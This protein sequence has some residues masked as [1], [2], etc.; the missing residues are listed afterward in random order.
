MHKKK[1]STKITTTDNNSLFHIALV[2]ILIFG[3]VGIVSA[4]TSVAWTKDIGDVTSVDM[5]DDGSVIYAAVQLSS[6]SSVVYIYSNA[7]V[8]QTEIGGINGVVQKLICTADGTQAALYTDADYVYHIN[9]GI[10]DWSQS[11]GA[12]V[13]DIDISNAGSVLVVQGT[14]FHKYLSNGN[15]EYDSAGGTYEFGVIDPDDEFAIVAQSGSA[16]LSK[17]ILS[18]SSDYWQKIGNNT[19]NTNFSDFQNLL[20]LY[21]NETSAIILNSQT[22]GNEIWTQIS[23]GFAV[24]NNTL[25]SDNSYSYYDGSI[26]VQETAS[27]G[28]GA[29]Y[30]ACTW[31][32]DGKMF[33]SSGLQGNVYK[34]DVWSSTDGSTWV[35]ETASAGWSGRRFAQSWVYDDKMYFGGG[36]YTSAYSDVWSSTN[37]STWV[38]ET[39]SAGWGGRWGACTWVYD[40]KMYLGGGS[41]TGNVYYNDVWSSTDGS[42]WVQETTSAGWGARWGACTWVYDGKMYLGGGSGTG[43][44]YYNDVWSSTDGSTWVQET[45]SAGWGARHGACT[46]VY[47]GK[48]YL[49]GGSGTGNVYYNDVWSSTDGSNWVQET[50]SAEWSGRGYFPMSWVYDN[51]MFIGGGNH[52]GTS[53]YADVW[54]SEYGSIKVSPKSSGQTYIFYN[55]TGSSPQHTQTTYS[56]AIPFTGTT[57]LRTKPTLSIYNLQ[58]TKTLTGNIQALSLSDRGDWL[59]TATTTRIYHDQITSAGFGTDYNAALGSSG[60]LYDIATAN[61]ASMSVVG[62]GQITDIYTQQASRVGTYTAGGAVQ[63]VDIAGKNA[64][65]A[66]SGGEDGK[67]YVFS[68]DASSNWY[69]EYSSDSEN[70][71]TALRMSARGEYVLAGRTNSLT[72]YQTNTPE[73]VQTDFWFTLYAYKDSDSYR[74]AA[75]NVSVYN[76]NQWNFLTQGLTDSVG[77]Y[78]ILLTAGQN[79]KFDV[80]NGEKIMIY[81]ATPNVNSQ[82]ISIYSS[83]ISS[84]V[85]YGATWD[86]QAGGIQ[87]KYADSSGQTQNLNVKIMRT[88]T[89]ETVYDETFT[90][91]ESINETLPI[92]DDT[93]SYKVE[94]SANRV[95]GVTRNNFFVSA[96]QDIIPIPL[97]KNIL[98][99]LF[100]CLLIL[101]AGLFS[102]MSAIR[103][104]VVVA[105]C[106]IFF[107]YLGWLT[108]PWHW[109]II[110]IVIAMVAGFTQRRS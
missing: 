108:I 41:G 99:V 28:W 95:S 4:D 10:I 48:M 89:W 35:Q 56:G 77:K 14:Q 1:E 78:V 67:V 24:S 17:Y 59:G 93:T 31:V 60:T 12:A 90:G 9:G 72:L 109:L 80:G 73:V 62:Q 49:G 39:T 106:A 104:A 51:K 32:Y 34:N 57:E 94:F 107:T 79:Y 36:L 33:L 26:W 30:G 82:T 81:Q 103:G 64:L 27:A 43:N 63:Y 13:T 91:T 102:Y 46:W 86:T 75:V 16:V 69:L 55:Y 19:F 44:V 65:W 101:I 98:N 2:C 21:T 58:T 97:D 6:A 105:M 70:P 84:S 74:N 96:S 45:A 15:L 29:R 54:Y 38:R 7:G 110:A 23:E 18:T 52:G 61:G 85:T 87:F 100:S 25:S 92:I 5:S 22:L 20:I 47:D 83:P 53:N 68:K 37:G 40:G 88:D 76:G 42:N 50:A 11:Y 71:I 66:T 8:E 3:I